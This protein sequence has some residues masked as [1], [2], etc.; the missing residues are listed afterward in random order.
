MN[1]SAQDLRPL[2]ETAESILG[3]GP[4]AEGVW[5]AAAW[6][7]LEESG[8]TTID[9][10][11]SLGGG[12][13]TLREAAE[14]V[15]VAGARA[16]RVPI[17]EAALVGAWLLGAAGLPVPSGPL[18]AAL[19]S[20]GLTADA[21]GALTGTVRRVPYARIASSVV[22][23]ADGPSGPVVVV[24][25]PS[26]AAVSEGTN[27]AGEPRDDLVLDGVS[28]T[29]A[30]AVEPAVAAELALRGALSR[31]VLAAGA[32][33]TALDLVL[34]HVSEREQF[35]RPIAKFQAVQ[36]LVAELAGEVASVTLSAEAALLAT[37]SGDAS[38][39]ATSVAAARVVSADASTRIAAIAHQLVAGIG[40][41][42]EHA[43]HRSTTRLWAWRDEGG[44]EG[45][46]ADRLAARAVD[47]SAPPLWQQVVGI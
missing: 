37:A 38:Y 26:T 45:F 28:P 5:D 13:G 33:Q 34:R 25:D 43:L 1:A 35:G 9:V 17:A 31:V 36:Q 20:A 14:V 29:A 39:A 10:P 12:G 8:L 15:R 47:P 42:R 27:L 11:E 18:T 19:D 7:A 4:S 32:G 23:L 21:S 46:W 30:A 44:T 24:V 3:A 41:T 6:A 40:V 16:V 2:T 22:L